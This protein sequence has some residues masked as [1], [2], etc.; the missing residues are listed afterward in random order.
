MTDQNHKNSKL[1]PL[2]IIYALTEV[3][4]VLGFI[5]LS[6]LALRAMKGVVNIRALQIEVFG[7]P[8]I[9]KAVF[10]I[11]LPI[12]IIKV[13]GEEPGEYGINFNNFSYHLKIGLKSL[14][15]VFLADLAFPL[16]NVLGFSYTDLG[17]ALILSFSNIMAL[18]LVARFLRKN[19]TYQEQDASNHRILFFFLIFIA[20][21]ILS[22]LTLPLGKQAG[23]FTYALFTTGFGEEIL[24]RGYVQSRLNRALGRPFSFSGVRWGFGVIIAAILFGAMH[25]FHGTGTLWWGVWTT[26]AGL[27]LGFLREKTG[28]IVA[29]GIAHGAP[30]AI[31][32]V[33]MGD[34]N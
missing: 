30:L 20:F 4:C 1:P 24:F 29:P 5:L 33:F 7:Q 12:M 15:I 16:V 18:V 21:T 28:S 31:V 22:A 23:S 11:L 8:I 9:A 27:V 19:L 14:T 25:F 34:I 10:V 6:G 2:K 13:R 32:Y 3:I 26:F 17:G